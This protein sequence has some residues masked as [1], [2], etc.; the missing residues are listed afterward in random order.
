MA[1][2]RRHTS[3]EIGQAIEGYGNDCSSNQIGR[4]GDG[5]DSVESPV[6]ESQNVEQYEL[7]IK[8]WYQSEAWP[9]LLPSDPLTDHS[10]SA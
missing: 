10:K 8:T 4:D 6:D 9:L 5:N 7:Q 2:G 3:E 1:S